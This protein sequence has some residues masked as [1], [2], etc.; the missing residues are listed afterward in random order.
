MSTRGSKLGIKQGYGPA[1]VGRA[2][3]ER[4]P[5]LYEQ[6]AAENSRLLVERS[7]E[8]LAR[9]LVKARITQRK[10]TLARLQARAQSMQDKIVAVHA[11]AYALQS[12]IAEVEAKLLVP[13]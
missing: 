7:R 9:G 5:E 4:F 12:A 6:L 8:R 2:L 11:K 13:V 10:K 3:K 1:P